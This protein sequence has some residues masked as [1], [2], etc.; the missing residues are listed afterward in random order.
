MD[1]SMMRGVSAETDALHLG[2]GWGFDEL[3]MPNVII[4]STYGESHPG[5]SHL[6][7]LSNHARDGVLSK[8]GKPSIFITTDICDGVAQGGESMQYSLLSREFIA[9][10]VEIHVKASLCDGLV[11]LSSCDKSMPAHILA[12]SRLIEYPCVVVPGGCM[13]AGSD[14][15]S[16]DQLW[17]LRKQHREGNIDL[18]TLRHCQAGACPSEGACQP[19]GTAGTMQVMAEALGLSLPG[20]ALI[21]VANNAIAR[22]A[23]TA[24]K[25]ILKLIKAGITAKD[26]LTK[27]AFENAIRVHAAIGGSTNAVLHLLAAAKERGIQITLDTFE[28]MNKETPYIVN[29]L[30]T[31]EYPT[32]LFWYAGGVPA[33]LNELSGLLNLDVLTVTGKTLKDNLEV[34]LSSGYLEAQNRYLVNYNIRPSEIIGTLSRPITRDGGLAIL[35]GNIAPKGAVVKHSAIDQSMHYFRGKA[36]VFDDEEKVMKAFAEKRIKKG[37]VVVIVDQG[38]KACGM[39]EMFRTS[40]AINHYEVEQIAV[41]TDGRYSGCTSGPAVGYISPETAV[42]GPIGLVEDGDLIEIDI[43]NRGINLVVEDGN[44]GVV[45]GSNIISARAGKMTPKRVGASEGVRRIY[46]KLV[47]ATAQGATMS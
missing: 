22:S 14:F 16:V 11:M 23:K 18:K 5:S 6:L 4:E 28:K 19:M 35:R 39:P 36:R 42:G 37:E 40:N 7:R 44:G 41:I 12:A 47:S 24:G 8:G 13:S 10:M 27:E 34:Y 32:E 15:L 46:Q 43:A 1:S 21:P 17:E 2:M 33:I 45:D 26:I 3:E 31:G 9:G 20:S 30:N 29:V 38:P 25:Q